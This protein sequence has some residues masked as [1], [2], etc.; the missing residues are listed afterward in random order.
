[1]YNND[2]VY[3]QKYDFVDVKS[4]EGI[5]YPITMKNKYKGTNIAKKVWIYEE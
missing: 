1:M 3:N 2:L 4:D 5:F